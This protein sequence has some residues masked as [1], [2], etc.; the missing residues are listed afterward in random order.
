[1]T[2]FS[3]TRLK[4]STIIGMVLVWLFAV[5]SGIVNACVLEQLGTAATVGHTEA[6]VGHHETLDASKAPCLKAC[7]D[8][9]QALGK[10]QTFF[11]LTDRGPAWPDAML[12]SAAMQIASAHRQIERSPAAT[13]EPPLRVRY[14]R[15]AL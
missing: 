12:W 4:R 15:L 3:D 13:S 14:S 9:S 8:G 5:S 10:L 7:D 1:M 2:R 11:D 6:L